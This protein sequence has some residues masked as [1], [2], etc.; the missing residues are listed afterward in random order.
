MIETSS[1]VLSSKNNNKKLDFFITIFMD[2][3]IY[4]MGIHLDSGKAYWGTVVRFDEWLLTPDFNN[5]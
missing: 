5:G 2:I 1:D 4:I 3:Y